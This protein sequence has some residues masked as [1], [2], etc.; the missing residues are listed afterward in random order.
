[1]PSLSATSAGALMNVL[2]L[3]GMAF[4]LSNCFGFLRSRP[5]GERTVSLAIAFGAMAVVSMMSSFPVGPGF[6]GDLRYVVI[7]I[8]AIIGGPLPALAA[9]AAAAVLRINFGGQLSAAILGI[10]LATALSIGYARLPAAKS[11]RN[12]ALLGVL[13]A[14]VNA[15]V[16]LIPWAQSTLSTEEAVLMG[17]R[18]FALG[19][20]VFP[21]A[22]IFLVSLLSREQHRAGEE[23]ELR[24]A[25]ADFLS[26]RAAR[27]ASLSVPP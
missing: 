12:L 6:I 4:L 22:I 27:R 3:L 14:V 9:A 16:L 19:V 5:E 26:N 21:I 2:A 7:A 18:F 11:S 25:N 17:T 1:M 24:T 13:L 8:A 23:S 10:G 20:V 15:S